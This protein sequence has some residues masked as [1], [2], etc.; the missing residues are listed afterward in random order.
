MAILKGRTD[1]MLL[2]D[3]GNMAIVRV[4]EDVM[5]LGEKGKISI[6]FPR[7]ADKCHRGYSVVDLNMIIMCS[8][9]RNLP[10]NVTSPHK[11]NCLFSKGRHFASKCLQPR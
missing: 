2:R 4:C 1:V 6:L 8:N 3:R 5:L 9:P 7:K 11:D 10:A